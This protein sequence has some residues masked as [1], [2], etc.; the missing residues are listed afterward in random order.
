MALPNV[1]TTPG[2]PT[3]LDF[4][5]P[6]LDLVVERLEGERKR[7][8]LDLGA[9]V[10]SNVEFFRGFPCRLYIEDL[11][12]NLTSTLPP[13]DADP[14]EID[15][16]GCVAKAFGDHGGVLFDVVLG[17]D[18]FSYMQPPV[19]SSVM[20]RL[21]ESCH[22]RTLLYMLGPTGSWIPDLPSR[23][24]FVPPRGVHYEPASGAV[25]ANPKHSPVKLERMMP[26]F[27][28]LHSFLLGGGMQ[29]FLFAYE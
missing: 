23:V 22:G 13:P 2:A 29:E 15:F 10:A 20:K 12:A 9:P 21:A 19:I 28:L 18:L 7:Y 1:S 4:K 11:Y 8:I 26:G 17:W 25:I 5:S 24:R 16:D 3:T 27:H 14:D 6:S